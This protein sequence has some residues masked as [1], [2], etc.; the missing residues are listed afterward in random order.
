MLF[1]ST[2]IVM[3]VRIRATQSVTASAA[4]TLV[5]TSPQ[6]QIT[7]S[8]TSGLGLTY[9]ST[10]PSICAVSG[11]GLI[12]A[13]AAGECVVRVTQAGSTTYA[14]ASTTVTVQVVRA[15]QSIS[16]PGSVTAVI[17]NAAVSIGASSSVGLALTYT[18][19]TPQFCLSSAGGFVS[20]VALGDCQVQISQSGNIIYAP[21]DNVIILVAIRN[22]QTITASQLNGLILGTSATISANS[23]SGLGLTFTSTTPLIC[24]VDSSGRVV[25]LMTGTCQIRLSQAGDSVWAASEKLISFAV[26]APR[27]TV[28]TK[29]V[30]VTQIVSATTAKAKYTWARPVN[31]VYSLPTSY[32]IK[33]RTI[34]SGGVASA[35]RQITVTRQ[36][37][38]SP[39]LKRGLT[40]VVQIAAN[41]P[42]G[43]GPVIK[44]TRKL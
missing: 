30:A 8:A 10:T 25:T 34:T 23:S 35:W 13:L 17:G 15:A 16:A 40:L 5:M 32:V 22:G 24:G 19:L 1:R 38:Y 44:T 12:T 41:G 14:A 37:W 3:T 28:V 18:S 36:L 7:A 2:T 31:H 20:A 33:W 39:M 43:V 27:P 42:G 4:S 21:A 26:V 29:V 11:T 6:T 9:T